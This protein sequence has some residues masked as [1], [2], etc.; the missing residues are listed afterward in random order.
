MC[1]PTDLFRA[2]LVTS[3]AVTKKVDRL[4]SLDMVERLPDPGNSGCFLIR[5]T[6]HGLKVVDETVEHLADHSLLGPAMAQFSDADRVL[7]SQIAFGTLAALEASGLDDVGDNA[8][9]ESAAK[10]RRRTRKPR[11]AA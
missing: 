8:E 5:L 11:A 3:G 10:V 2:L 1:G 4:A 9:N 7:V 6:R